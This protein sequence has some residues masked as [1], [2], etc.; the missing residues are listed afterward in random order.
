[1]DR[2]GGFERRKDPNIEGLEHVGSICRQEEYINSIQ[3]AFPHK[4]D[5]RVAMMPVNNQ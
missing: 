3:K 1:M 4:I 2:K 5:H